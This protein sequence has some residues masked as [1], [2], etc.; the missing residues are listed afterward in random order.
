[1][2]IANVTACVDNLLKSTRLPRNSSEGDIPLMAVVTSPIESFECIFK[3]LGVSNSEVTAP[4]GTGRV[5]LYTGIAKAGGT[6]AP[7]GSPNETTLWGSQDQLNKYD[8]VFFPCQGVAGSHSTA[9]QN[10]LINYVN[11]GGRVMASHLQYTWLFNISPFNT[12]AN[13]QVQQASPPNQNGFIDMTFNKG[14][15]LAQFLQA[16]GVT[17]TLGQFFWAKL[18]KDLNTTV[19]PSKTWISLADGTTVLYTFNTPLGA[20]PRSQCGR[21]TYWD[22]HIEAAP[23]GTS[24]VYPVGCNATAL[25]QPAE[26]LLVQMMFDLMACISSDV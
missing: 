23:P 16:R 26:R 3:I 2:T 11:A 10:R 6:V 17:S 20:S 15:L 25:G 18:A 22:V 13:W 14:L 9:D 21:V 24:L 12:T 8:M 5:H 4:N 19:P 1:M 7:G